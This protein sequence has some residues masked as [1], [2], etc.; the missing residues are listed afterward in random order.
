MHR[1]F[2]C[3]RNG[4]RRDA[5]TLIELLV[6]ISIIAL[7]I[8]ILLP[9]L[10]SARQS[11]RRVQCASNS[12][13]LLQSAVTIAVDNDGRFRLSQRFLNESDSY[14][15][16]YDPAVTLSADH[17]SWIA[18]H[19]GEDL[20]EV[21]MNIEC[22][23]CPERGTEYI[24]K[25]LNG[26][27]NLWRMGYY[28]MPGRWTSQ[29]KTID[30]N[31]WVAPES[32]EDAA[33]LVMVADVTERGTYDP[34]NATGS[35]GPGGLVVGERFATPAELGVIGSNVGRLDGSVI[36]E[37]VDG[38]VEF[39]ASEGFSPGHVSGYWVDTASYDNP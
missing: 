15:A 20:E 8:A 14:R 16:G 36:F 30:G 32:L 1:G 6:V 25:D 23:T 4:P 33:D 29:F 34:P 22:F 11:A 39:A 38:L 28:F 17:I 19:Y 10:S 2:L 12:R 21:G 5:F 37:R 9:A 24:R 7:L 31:S 18:S 13:S 27:T 35:H 26:N 3:R